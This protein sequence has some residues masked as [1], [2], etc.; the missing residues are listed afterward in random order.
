MNRLHVCPK[1][2]TIVGV[3]SMLAL[4]SGSIMATAVGQATGPS[5][6]ASRGPRTGSIHG[7]DNKP[8]SPAVDEQ[9]HSGPGEQSPT[10]SSG[11]PSDSWQLPLS[12]LSVGFGAVG[13]ALAAVQLRG[14]GFTERKVRAVHGD[15]AHVHGDLHLVPR[16]ALLLDWLLAVIR[17]MR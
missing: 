14:A 2:A 9:P 4:L 5:P 16:T 8:V 6:V 11:S 15:V 3:C 7:I 12:V 1:T 17:E 10:K 13:L